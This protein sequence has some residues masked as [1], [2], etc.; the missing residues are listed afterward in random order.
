[1]G[2]R[3]DLQLPFPQLPFYV[4]ALLKLLQKWRSEVSGVQLSRE[5]IIRHPGIGLLTYQILLLLQGA[6][7]FFLRFLLAD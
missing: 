5:Q 4:L 2:V 3:V 1:M 6:H 7:L